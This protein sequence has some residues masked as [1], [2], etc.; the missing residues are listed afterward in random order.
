MTKAQAE[1]IAAAEDFKANYLFPGTGDFATRQN[2][3]TSARQRLWRALDAVAAE[4]EGNP[5]VSPIAVQEELVPL[6]GPDEG[7]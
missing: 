7:Q 2:A 3:Y 6:E 4:R 5:F 1:A